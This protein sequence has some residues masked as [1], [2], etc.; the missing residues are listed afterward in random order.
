MENILE[1]KNNEINNIKQESEKSIKKLNEKINILEKEL[2]K[3]KL[4]KNDLSESAVK[5][6]FDLSYNINQEKSNFKNLNIEI[7]K[8]KNENEE[9]IIKLN[10][11]EN[12]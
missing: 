6:I 1:N 4:E 7:T 5:K 9:L 11:N 10:N 2:E 12:K 8:L 3:E